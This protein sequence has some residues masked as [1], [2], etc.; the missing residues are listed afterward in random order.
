MIAKAT[1][2]NLLTFPRGGARQALERVLRMFRSPMGDG[3]FVQPMG[4]ESVAGVSDPTII[5][6]Q[7]D[8]DG[9]LGGRTPDTTNI[10]GNTWTDQS[11]IGVTESSAAK[12]YG[13][14]ARAFIQSGESN[15]ILEANVVP[16]RAADAVVCGLMFRYSD[17]N[18]YW[19]VGGVVATQ[20]F[21]LWVREGGNDTLMDDVSA[22]FSLG[23]TYA[24]KV[25]ANG[26]SITATL[27]GGNELSVTS[28]FN[29]SA[30][31]HG[32]RKGEG[33]YN[34]YWQDFRVKTV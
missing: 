15:V 34:S 26:T 27:D 22:T 13:D 32:L 29:Q 18:N 12:P 23:V 6:D 8:G 1:L 11:G 17:N 30:T 33:G 28:S 3:A 2:P 14:G 21:E 31:I 16:N 19:Y 10:P 25:T 5:Y 7:F 4:G 20:R 9:A 24:L